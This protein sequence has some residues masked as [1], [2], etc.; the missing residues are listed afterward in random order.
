MLTEVNTSVMSATATLDT[1]A[2][3]RPEI[4]RYI[5]LYG[6]P[7]NNVFD[8]DKLAAIIQEIL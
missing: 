2:E 1:I 6:Y 5:E 3:I 8:T 7:G 4:I